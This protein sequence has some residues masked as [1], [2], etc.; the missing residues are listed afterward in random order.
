MTVEENQMNAVSAA[1]RPSPNRTVLQPGPRF[2]GIQIDADSFTRHLGPDGARPYLDGFQDGAADLAPFLTLTRQPVDVWVRLLDKPITLE[3]Q[4]SFYT[5]QCAAREYSTG[6]TQ[7]LPEA[8]GPLAEAPLAF[9]PHRI[10]SQ[11]LAQATRLA[12]KGFQ[13]AETPAVEPVQN[14]YFVN[15][16]SL[17]QPAP[18]PKSQKAP[19]SK[20]GTALGNRPAGVGY[21]GDSLIEKGTQAYLEVKRELGRLTDKAD[22]L[23]GLSERDRALAKRESTPILKGV[24]MNSNR[25]NKYLKLFEARKARD[26][27]GMTRRQ[28]FNDLWQDFTRMAVLYKTLEQN[29]KEKTIRLIFN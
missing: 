17:T 7:A 20:L 9:S 8:A 22:K 26:P 10:L 29:V 15:P 28:D 1:F 16:F 27:N 13:T 12:L 14:Q 25:V 11:A 6:P 5:V 21:T 3:G 18:A 4:S 2:S 24:L 19:A 23:S